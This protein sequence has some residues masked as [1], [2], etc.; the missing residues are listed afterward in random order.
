VPSDEVL[1]VDG[2][3]EKMGWGR[4]GQVCLFNISPIAAL[5][6]V[7]GRGGGPSSDYGDF[8]LDF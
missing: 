4:Y 5:S 7:F 3:A 6:L 1:S 8:S 2:L